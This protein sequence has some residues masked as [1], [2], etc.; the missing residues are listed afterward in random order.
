[1]KPPPSKSVSATIIRPAE[2]RDLAASTEI[3]RHHVLTSP[4]T[5]ELDSP[6]RAEMERRFHAIRERGYDYFVAGE[7]GEIVGYAYATAF[8]ARSAY[9][10]TVENSVYARRSPARR[11]RPLPHAGA[12]GIECRKGFP[13]DD[14][15]D[16]R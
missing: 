8:R 10:F 7:T 14:R 6:D 5:F 3:C 4:A 11:H 12:Y 13:P 15:G 1:M 9:R 16:R 2:T